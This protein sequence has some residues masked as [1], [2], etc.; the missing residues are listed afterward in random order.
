MASTSHP[1]RRGLVVIG[2]RLF[3][4]CFGPCPFLE[5]RAPLGWHVEP[6]S[7]CLG[8]L[9]ACS[10]P[11]P[12]WPRVW[13]GPGVGGWLWGPAETLPENHSIPGPLRSHTV[14]CPTQQSPHGP[15]THSCSGTGC[16]GFPVLASGDS[17]QSLA[18]ARWWG[19]AGLTIRAGGGGVPQGIRWETKSSP[20]LQ[21]AAGRLPG[22]G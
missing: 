21:Q 15:S 2:G 1:L 8:T 3:L 9:G 4:G 10:S 12:L 7:R 20:G 17:L 14:S 22:T 6:G 11:S 5:G 13:H 18:Q 19:I 16:W